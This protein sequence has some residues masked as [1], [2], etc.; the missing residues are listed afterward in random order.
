MMFIKKTRLAAFVKPPKFCGRRMRPRQTL[1]SPEHK[2]MPT[3]ELSVQ[4]ISSVSF[5]NLSS[6]QSRN[7]VDF[8]LL[9]VSQNLKMLVQERSCCYDFEIV[10]KVLYFVRVVR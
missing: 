6:N 2:K 9:V 10:C 7:L 4:N 1:G 8:Q 5:Y 3:S